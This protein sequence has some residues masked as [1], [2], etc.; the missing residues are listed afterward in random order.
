[1]T[2]IY[3]P[4]NFDNQIVVPKEIFG[5]SLSMSSVGFY[6]W[7]FTQKA[8]VPI[9]FDVIKKTFNV[10]NHTI[11]K[12]IKELENSKFLSKIPI[13]NAGKFGGFSY[14]I[15]NPTM[16]KKPNPVNLIRS[17]SLSNIINNT[18]NNINN[19][20]NNTNTSNINNNIN[21]N[22]NNSGKFK[23]ENLFSEINKNMEH[24]MALFPKKYWPISEQ[25]K[26]KWIDCIYK[27][28]TIDKYKLKELYV[29]IKKIRTD[30]FWSVNFLTI[31]KIRKKNKDGIKYID[32]F[33]ELCKS[34]RPDAYYKIK[35]LERYFVYDDNNKKC[36]GAVAN[37][38]TLMSYNLERVLTE[39]EIKEIIEY[40]EIN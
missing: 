7:L 22:N 13:R 20:S 14:Y 26:T 23:D 12:Q 15:A 19:T 6:C 25:E 39:K 30:N 3:K 21:N 27:A 17:Q 18:N 28:V 40:V 11:R 8:N 29:I 9:T 16:L 31:L 10:S 33:N 35:N 36:L 2:K 4:P 24:F 37:N 38:T 32:F 5:H 1:M 34:K